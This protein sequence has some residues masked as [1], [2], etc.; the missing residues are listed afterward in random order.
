M[1]IGDLVKIC[2][3][4]LHYLEGRYGIVISFFSAPTYSMGEQKWYTV[5]IDDGEHCFKY[6]DIEVINE[7]R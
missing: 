5:L 7:S 4:T 3:K 2:T 6:T 1:K